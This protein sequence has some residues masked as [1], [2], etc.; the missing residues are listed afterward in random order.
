MSRNYSFV[1][2][3]FC[4]HAAGFRFVSFPDNSFVA[5]GLCK[6][7]AGFWFVRCPDQ[8]LGFENILLKK[9]DENL[10]VVFSRST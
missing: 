8:R 6:L 9:S 2:N 10:S 7:A 5:N 3:G 4:K 1:A